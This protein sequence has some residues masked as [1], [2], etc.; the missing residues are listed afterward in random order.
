MPETKVCRKCNEKKDIKKFR[1]LHPKR[2]ASGEY[3]SYRSNSCNICT[4]RETNARR[5]PEQQEAWLK[6]KREGRRQRKIEAI[7]YKGGKCTVCKGEF[8]T[9]A[10]DFH[11]RN[12]EE[13]KID[14]GLLM[15]CRD[16]V[17][18]KELDKCDLLCANCH[19]ILHYEEGTLGE[20][21]RRKKKS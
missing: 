16:E 15:Q 6:T 14:P 13:K 4:N 17:L 7:A 9:A 10:F 21:K 3:K 1:R 20:I 8:H 5:T 18:Y 19:R 12:P 2:L 11:H